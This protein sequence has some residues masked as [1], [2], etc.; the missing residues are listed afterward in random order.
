MLS[1]QAMLS[2]GGIQQVQRRMPQT[3]TLGGLAPQHPPG[4]PMVGIGGHLAPGQPLMQRAVSGPQLGAGQSGMLF[5]SQRTNVP[6][7]GGYLGPAVGNPIGMMAS[8]NVPPPPP[9]GMPIVGSPLGIGA[10]AVGS[11]IMMKQMK[12]VPHLVEQQQRRRPT[13]YEDI[14]RILFDLKVMESMIKVLADGSVIV[15]Y[16]VVMVLSN[17]V[18][19]YL[20]A[21]LVIAEDATRVM[22]TMRLEKITE[23]EEGDGTTNHS[24]ESRARV[25]SLPQGVNQKIMERFEESWK[26]LRKIQH[27]DPH[28]NVSGAANKI[29]RVV[30]ETL[31]DMRMELDAKK[32][33]NAID[34][35]LSEI[36]E[37]GETGRDGMDRVKS[38]ANISMASPDQREKISRALP[39]SDGP[40]NRLPAMKMKPSLRRSSSEAAGGNFPSIKMGDP[41]SVPSLVMPGRNLMDRVKV[42]NLLPKSQ[43]YKWKK[44][45]FRPDNDDENVGDRDPLNPLEAA[46]NY[47]NRRN[48]IVRKAGCKLAKH[49]EDLKPRRENHQH[50]GL[51]MFLDDNDDGNGD[52]DVFLQSELRLKEKQ[53]LRNNGGVKM[54]SMLKFHSYENA[55]AVCDNQ[56]YVSIW[57]YEK[58]T[59]KSSFK[60]GNPAGSRMTSA[61]WINESS[62]SLLFVGCDDGSA[63]IW[64]GL[65]QNN[66]PISSQ[67]PT[68]ESSFFAIPDMEAGQRSKSGLICEWQQAT[69]TLVSGGNSRQ[70]RCWDMTAEK[71]SATIDIESDSCITALTTAWDEV[72]NTGF[73]G[74][75]PEIIVA[76]FSDGSLKLFDIR[77]PRSGV[78]LS[79]AARA[80][81]SINKGRGRVAGATTTNRRKA[82]A[83]SLHNRTFNEHTSWIVDVSFTSYGGNGTQ[84]EILSGSVAGDIRAWDIR[85]PSRS[86]RAI[87]V[88]RSPMTA[89]SVHKQI[90][91]VATG[92]HAQF[93]K[94]LTLEGETLQVARFHEESLPG[95]RIGPV[96]CLEF[97]EQKLVLAAGS[98]NA[99]VSIYQPRRPRS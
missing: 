53:L 73:R 94:I 96:S 18:E 11:P 55:L 6:S 9:V 84:N 7:I 88:Q 49:F 93:M 71:C 48:S 97:H 81:N 92:S 99:L 52:S 59:Q 21:I 70:L 79:A 76:G 39:Q 66:G 4:V 57:D 51:N 36:Q 69:G 50:G 10:S 17:F 61:F 75:G 33:R 83:A 67:A 30:H 20:Q 58:G 23:D 34:S 29:V 43:F 24:R 56:D 28:P 95:H 62:S 77:T 68:L 47:Q 98:T 40:S 12:V 72:N 63:R 86:V 13:V 78:A 90:P 27:E 35:G 25:V 14:R 31:Y 22:D 85:T 32:D 87:E 26:A 65:V 89:L 64:R 5:H 19:K 82:A 38:D 42:E 3:P 91:I 80:N 46:R 45:F 1:S 54:T 41:K 74:T 37:E 44:T 16:E 15:R 2:Q 60:N 8:P